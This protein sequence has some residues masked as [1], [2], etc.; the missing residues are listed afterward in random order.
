[1][2][3]DLFRRNRR[4]CIESATVPDADER[5]G[6]MQA[7]PPFANR[8][9]VAGADNSMAG[10]ANQ[11]GAAGCE[12]NGLA[13]EESGLPAVPTHTAVSHAE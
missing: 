4:E 3:E 9:P 7:G 5:C 12:Q 10:P 1:M 11:S 2:L 6:G 8:P 13:Q